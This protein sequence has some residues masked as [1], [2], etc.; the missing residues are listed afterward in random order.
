MRLRKLLL[1]LLPVA[2]LAT[3]AGAFLGVQPYD[4]GHP[5]DQIKLSWNGDPHTSVVII[6]HA[7]RL[8][9]AWATVTGD[10]MT[11]RTVHGQRTDGKTIGP[12]FWLRAEVTGLQPGTTYRYMINSGPART[13][14][15]RFTTEPAGAHAVRF[16]VFADQGDCLHFAAACRVMEGI[17][18][19]RPQFV[20]GAGDLSY[21]DEADNG[22]G[23]ADTWANDIMRH[24]STWAPLLPT[25]GNH[26]YL[27]GDT[28]DN[29]RGR[30]G[31]PLKEPWPDGL[32]QSSGNG[33]YYSFTYG[34]V[35]VVAL[36]ERYISMKAG[37]RFHQW[38]EADLRRA[39]GDPAI[40]WR[41]AFDHRPFYSTGQRHGADHTYVKWV[42]PVLEKYHFDVVFSGHEHEYERTRPMVEGVPRSLSR[43]AWTQGTGITYVVTGG[44]GAPIYNDFGTP[45]RW[46]AVRRTG[47]E[48]VRVDIDPTGRTLRL[49][50]IAD[51][52]GHV[53]FDEFLITSRARPGPM[54]ERGTVR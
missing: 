6:W 22:P 36:P 2:F 34:P 37:S 50:A 35:H 40:K 7:D 27:P 11:S 41:I 39:A 10:G 29:Y 26:E 42:R 13:P 14:F 49:T 48:H 45:Q 18:Q 15:Y 51:D 38:L 47:H 3:A 19:D 52:D 4:P 30:L 25:P 20:L 44:G 43:T 53:P 5:A 9:A 46:D 24:Y 33:D 31:V 16:D 54:D 32:S 23:A 21:A 28:I 1:A 12:G 17:A 8:E